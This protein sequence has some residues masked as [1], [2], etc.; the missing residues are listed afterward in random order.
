LQHYG[1]GSHLAVPRYRHCD[2]DPIAPL[3]RSAILS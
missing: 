1:S 3:A 2:S